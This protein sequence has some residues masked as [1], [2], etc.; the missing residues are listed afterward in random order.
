[1]I[2]ASNRV[3]NGNDFFSVETTA[4]GIVQ[5]YYQGNVILSSKSGIYNGKWTHIAV[6][7]REGVAALYINGTLESENASVAFSDSVFEKPFVVAS[8]YT[9]SNC[10]R[11]EMAYFRAFETVCT[12]EQIRQIAF[13]SMVQEW[14][15]T[16][17]HWN[18]TTPKF[19]KFTDQVG[20]NAKVLK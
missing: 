12:V 5:V 1:M 20:N 15:H 11:G 9:L 16:I 2:I 17:A 13:N 19:D 4:A 7:L 18:F 8:D 14:L 10:L 6:T 3:A